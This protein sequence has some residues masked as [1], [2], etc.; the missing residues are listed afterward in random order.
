MKPL[1]RSGP[2]RGQYSPELEAFQED[3][4]AHPVLGTDIYDDRR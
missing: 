4:S 3:V 1:P 2:S